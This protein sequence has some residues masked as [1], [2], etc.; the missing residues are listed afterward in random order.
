M[1]HSAC[2]HGWKNLLNWVENSYWSFS[3]DSTQ[4]DCSRH[5]AK[6]FA[7]DTLLC[8]LFCA[9][10]T[11]KDLDRITFMR[12]VEFSFT[13][14]RIRHRP[15]SLMNLVWFGFNNSPVYICL[16]SY[17]ATVALSF[18]TVLSFCIN[19]IIFYTHFK[20]EKLL[21]VWTFSHT[22]RISPENIKNKRTIAGRKFHFQKRI[23][24]LTHNRQMIFK[25]LCLFATRV[26]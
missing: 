23:T 3:N 12:E 22:W 8:N 11:K 16:N 15:V 7:L 13:P 26:D 14:I 18:L 10:K 5:R 17:F 25:K 19:E 4:I 9:G 1:L 6:I 21:P 24:L 2:W 20:R